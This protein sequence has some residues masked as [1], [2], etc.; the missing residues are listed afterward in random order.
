MQRVMGGLHH[1]V[2]HIL[3]GQKPQNGRDG[4]WFYPPTEDAMA[5]AGL[6]E[7]ETYVSCRQNTVAQYIATRP[8]TDLCMVAKQ[9][10]GQRVEMRWWE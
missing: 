9:S 3:M 2:A 10:P 7:V 8:I 1:R 4:R 5:E 6:Q